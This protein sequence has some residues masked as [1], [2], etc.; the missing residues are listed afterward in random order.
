MIYGRLETVSD[1]HIV[2]AAEAAYTTLFGLFMPGIAS[3]WANGVTGLSLN[4]KEEEWR[5][6][7]M[8]AEITSSTGMNKHG[9]VI[10]LFAPNTPGMAHQ[11]LPAGRCANLSGQVTLERPVHVKR[12]VGVLVRTPSVIATDIVAVSFSYKVV[13]HER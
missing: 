3:Y 4:A 2:S 5:V 1:S 6:E 12:G 9:R 10:V 13:R 7:S 8:T 11:F